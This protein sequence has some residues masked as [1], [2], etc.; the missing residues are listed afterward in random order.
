MIACFSTNRT[1]FIY[2]TG[3]ETMRYICLI[4]SSEDGIDQVTPEQWQ[5]VTDAYNAFGAEA[6]AAGVV[7][8]SEALQPT[9]TATTVRVRDGKSLITDGPF[10]ETK[11]A[12]GGYYVLECK[13]LDEALA[14]AAKIPGAQHGC[15]E[16]RPIIE[17]S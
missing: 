10:A 6:R 14:W 4:Y 16:V 2:L 15:V 1:P 11:E 17:F 7:R 12:L 9:P 5:A 3:E 8:E 13:D